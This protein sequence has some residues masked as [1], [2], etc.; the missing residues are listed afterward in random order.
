MVRRRHCAAFLFQK[1]WTEWKTAGTIVG[2]SLNTLH[3]LRMELLLALYRCRSLTEGNHML[4]FHSM[5][6]HEISIPEQMGVLQ[7]GRTL[8]LWHCY[9]PQCV[10]ME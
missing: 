2:L 1:A 7:H 6:F 3:W 4:P 5:C 9:E 8:S 10:T